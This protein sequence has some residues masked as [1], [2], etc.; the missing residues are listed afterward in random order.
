MAPSFSIQ[1]LTKV[2]QFGVEPHELSLFILEFL[3]IF[4]D[5]FSHWI[6]SLP[7]WPDWLASESLEAMCFCSPA[8]GSRHAPLG[9]TFY[10]NLG[11]QTLGA[12]HIQQASASLNHHTALSLYSPAPTLSNSFYLLHAFSIILCLNIHG[13]FTLDHL[14]YRLF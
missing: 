3:L 11:I 13:G 8:Q 5:R 1:H 2:L 4:W 9:L 12:V 6:W 7:F 10:G 14:L